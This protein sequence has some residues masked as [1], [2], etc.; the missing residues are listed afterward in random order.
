MPGTHW[1]EEQ[2]DALR[3]AIE[4]GLDP[5]DDA[6]FV[7]EKSKH[8]VVSQAIRRGWIQLR[9]EGRENWPL[10]QRRR[11]AKAKRE[12]LNPQEIFDRNLLG[13]P[14][15]SL[16]AIK[17]QWGRMKLSCKR[18]RLLCQRPSQCGFAQCVWR[19]R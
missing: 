9:Y 2:I 10:A 8:A 6:V 18:R 4:A 3:V 16:W 17:K 7:P 19:I 12:G 13:S 5:R 11:L 15:R 14:H 1:T